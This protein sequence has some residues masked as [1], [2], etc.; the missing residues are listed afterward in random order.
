MGYVGKIREKQLA[1]KLR[2]QGHSYRDI[3]KRTNVSKDTVSR[4]C[5]DIQLSQEQINNLISNKANGLKKG[6][7]IGAQRNKEKR[8]AEE[9]ELL[10]IGVK[11][12]GRLSRRDRFII[13]ISLYM[14]EGSKTSAGVEFTNSDCSA[15]KFMVDWF[16]EFCQISKNQI[17]CSL[18]LHDNLDENIAKCF[19]SHLLN[20]HPEQFGKTYLS[21]NRHNNP[22]KQLHSYGI[23]KVRFYNI[24][25]LRLIKG[26][27]K[28]I[29]SN[30]QEC[31]NQ[32]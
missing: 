20:I 29:L 17:R 6:S 5:R 4:W 3:T 25:K 32:S 16:Q 22:R 31:Y 9:S 14:A 19:W 21:K 15:V 1:T 27:I 8:M 10:L 26:W 2:E 24:R 23:I 18:W 12:V 11:Q 28:G 7:L 30:N 13:G